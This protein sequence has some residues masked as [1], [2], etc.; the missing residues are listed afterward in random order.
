[1][2]EETILIDEEFLIIRDFKDD[3]IKVVNMNKEKNNFYNENAIDLE[4]YYYKK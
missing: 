4:K 2:L 1:M 3:D